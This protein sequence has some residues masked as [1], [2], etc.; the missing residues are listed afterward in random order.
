M[1]H[2]A[3][4]RRGRALARLLAAATVY[5]ASLLLVAAI[6]IIGVTAVWALWGVLGVR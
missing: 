3:P 6:T 1:R 2:A 5:A 4:H